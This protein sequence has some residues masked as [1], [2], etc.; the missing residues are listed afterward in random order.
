MAVIWLILF[1]GIMMLKKISAF[2]CFAIV[3]SSC[4]SIEE[5]EVDYARTVSGAATSSAKGGICDN[6]AYALTTKTPAG[7][8]RG[9]YETLYRKYTSVPQIKKGKTISVHLMQGFIKDG[10][11]RRTASEFLRGRA[12]NAEI[13]VI[14]NVCE[15]GKL[16]CSQKFGPTHDK[17]GR[18]VFFSNGVKAKQYMNFSYLPVYG[19][20]K[21]EGGPLILQLT[22]IERDDLS[23]QEI[24]MLSSL[25]DEGKKLYPPASKTLSLLDTLGKS[26]LAQSSDDV[27][28][29]HSMTLTPGTGDHGYQNP[30]IATGNYAFIRKDTVQG[31]QEKEIWHEIKFDHLSGRLVKRCKENET[32]TP[33]V[34]DEGEITDTNDPCA[35]ALATGEKFKDYRDNTYLTFQIQS[36]F[37]EASLDDLQTFE[38][39]VTDLS[40]AK[41][42]DASEVIKAAK[43]LGAE[44]ASNAKARELHRLLAE[45]K[46]SQFQPGYAQKELFSRNVSNFT[47][48]YSSILGEYNKKCID[49]KTVSEKCNELI[50][51][52]QLD[53][54]FFDTH[55]LLTA[56][57]TT[58]DPSVDVNTLLPSDLNTKKVFPKLAELNKAFVDGYKSTFQKGVFQNYRSVFQDIRNLSNYASKLKADYNKKLAEDVDYNAPLT[59][60]DAQTTLKQNLVNYFNQLSSDLALFKQAK[61]NNTGSMKER[62]YQYPT[63]DQIGEIV[64]IVQV[65]INKY[66]DSSSL[67]TLD[68]ADLI[69]EGLAASMINKIMDALIVIKI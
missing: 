25:S 10:L 47:T 61:C 6:G 68:A 48:R 34:N 4:A 24:A 51:K 17:K 2:I 54:V 30:I 22:I 69:N 53:N 52:E 28:F 9:C 38:E 3:L 18:V 66:N 5:G 49:A 37:S 33:L 16:G 64:T 29:R 40:N 27:I 15:Q 50:S 21:Y 41:D 57:V 32:G 60:T 43:K 31:P 11:E 13:V 62:C 19:P 35:I 7:F 39:L 36:G 14:A 12:A 20:I 8:T 44:L 67:S 59:L 1:K 26:L 56:L 42:K 58:L 23:N 65:Y 46:K 45:V 55:S 63:E